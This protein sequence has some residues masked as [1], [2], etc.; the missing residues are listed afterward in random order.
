MLSNIFHFE[1]KLLQIWLFIVK[2]KN[3]ICCHNRFH[4]INF[5]LCYKSIFIMDQ[6]I[7]TRE[8]FTNI[9]RIYT[10][11]PTQHSNP[12]FS[13]FSSSFSIFAIIEPCIG[14]YIFI[15]LY[16]FWLYILTVI[17][18]IYVLWSTFW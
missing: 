5:S 13:N 2:K 4:P 14:I 15:Y 8:N 12:N 17:E 10:T 6:T 1:M 9:M 3:K 18:L 7:L 16:F 11:L